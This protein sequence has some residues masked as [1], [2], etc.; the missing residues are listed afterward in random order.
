MEAVWD[1]WRESE[2]ERELVLANWDEF[3]E[4]E[5]VPLKFEELQSEYT[6]EKAIVTREFRLFQLA[7]VDLS[8]VAASAMT[9]LTLSL[10]L[11]YNA[12]LY[13]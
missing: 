1:V 2:G 9:N 12:I 11:I 8:A 3:F 13:I 7:L 4:G 5:N 6:T 10:F